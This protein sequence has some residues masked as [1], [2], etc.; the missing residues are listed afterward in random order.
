MGGTFDPIHHGHLFAAEEARARFRLDPVIFIPCGQPP[1]KADQEI[2]PAECRYIMCALATASNPHFEVSRLEIDRP[3]PSY[4]IETLRHYRQRLGPEAELFFVTGADAILEILTWREP[5]AVLREA[6]CIAVN[7]PGSDLSHLSNAI[8]EHRAARIE[9]LDLPAIEISSTGIR[10]R[11]RKGLPIRYLTPDVVVD[12]IT[13][14]GLY[15][16]QG[17][18]VCA[19]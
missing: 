12:Y 16:R 2:S 10:D 6:R 11:A 4:T 3:G 9:V 15:V 19:T 1:H 8:G 13:K 17:A 5:D 14:E 7:R 18:G